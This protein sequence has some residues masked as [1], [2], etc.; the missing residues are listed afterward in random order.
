MAVAN[1]RACSIAL[2]YAVE[3]CKSIL[4]SLVDTVLKV[5]HS[6]NEDTQFEAKSTTV[7]PYNTLSLSHPHNPNPPI[8]CCLRRKI[9]IMLFYYESLESECDVFHRMT[10]DSEGQE[11][12]M[13]WQ[14][15]ER[16]YSSIPEEA[17]LSYGRVFTQRWMLR[18]I[19]AFTIAS[20][21]EKGEDIIVG[22]YDGLPARS[23]SEWTKEDLTAFRESLVK[24]KKTVLLASAT[25][26]YGEE[27]KSTSDSSRCRNNIYNIEK[28]LRITD[29]NVI[30]SPLRRALKKQLNDIRATNEPKVDREVLDHFLKDVESTND[31]IVKKCLLTLLEEDET[32]GDYKLKDLNSLRSIMVKSGKSPFSLEKFAAK[33]I[34]TLI[35]WSKD[36]FEVPKLFASYFPEP[37]EA[38]EMGLEDD[39]DEMDEEEHHNAVRNLRS[40]RTGLQGKGVDPLNETLEQASRVSRPT[41]RSPRLDHQSNKSNGKRARDS[42]DIK[43]SPRTVAVSN[44]NVEQEA[45]PTNERSSLERGSSSRK[46]RKSGSL[47]T[48]K[49]SARALSFD[50]SQTDGTEILSE[51]GADAVLSELPTRATPRSK[52]VKKRNNDTPESQRS[53]G[54]TVAKSQQKKYAGRRRWTDEEKRA[55]KEGIRQKGVGNWAQIKEMYKVVLKDRTSGQI[56]DCFRTMK[57]R[58][59]LDWTMYTNEL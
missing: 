33:I 39:G 46:R 3:C 58:D 52:R 8:Q 48:K 49:S 40:A 31:Q 9:S 56:K 51:P 35:L 1:F 5:S 7:T 27:E 50:D 20:M 30:L 23:L 59:E 12:L 24:L 32:T 17:K 42:Q 13:Y 54:S 36:M 6:L 11:R 38:E 37:S 22:E 55:I 53:S 28:I 15:F 29:V 47:Y 21:L 44:D 16:Y 57:K 2:P 4:D 34:K 25:A 26:T 41:R 45:S 43:R 10:I 19:A 18:E 14:C